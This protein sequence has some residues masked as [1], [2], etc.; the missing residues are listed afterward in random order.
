MKAFISS[1]V[2]VWNPGKF[3]LG[4]ATFNFFLA[5]PNITV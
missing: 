2:M 5:P 1:L 4:G 3:G